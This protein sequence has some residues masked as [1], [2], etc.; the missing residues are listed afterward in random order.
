MAANTTRLLVCALAGVFLAGV[1]SQPTSSGI[2]GTSLSLS[3]LPSAFNQPMPTYTVSNP[4]PFVT[5]QTIKHPLCFGKHSA[6]LTSVCVVPTGTKAP[7][8]SKALPRLDVQLT[9][10]SP[11]H[12]V[13]VFLF[14]DED[15]A[16]SRWWH[17]AMAN[18]SCAAMKEYAKSVIS[19]GANGVTTGSRSITGETS[20]IWYIMAVDC[21][22]RQCPNISNAEISFYHPASDGSRDACSASGGELS[23][24][25]LKLALNQGYQALTFRNVL[26]VVG[27]SPVGVV[28]LYTTCVLFSILSI[29]AFIRYSRAAS[30]GLPEE[31]APQVVVLCIAIVGGLCYLAMATGSGMVVLRKVGPPA[32]AQWTYSNP[33]MATPGDHKHKNPFYDPAY[34]KAP[35]YPLF[36]VRF[37]EWGVFSA[38]V[39]PYL[40]DIAG[41]PPSTSQL[42]LILG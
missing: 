4:S 24:S 22:T 15:D 13:T 17:D 41:A 30:R 8:D 10:A 36:Y 21:N 35:T 5:A 14:D 34:A 6:L 11:L 12:P 19:P 37:V 40:A 33:M 18:R 38:V 42:L 27:V 7:Q 20:Q 25:A 39:L 3:M 2:A 9:P 28:F 26:S 31:A 16:Y 1:G 23:L 29:V 32:S